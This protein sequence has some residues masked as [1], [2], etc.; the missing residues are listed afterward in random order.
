MRLLV[1]MWIWGLGKMMLMKVFVLCVRVTGTRMGGLDVIVDAGISAS[2][3]N[4]GVI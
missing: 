1:M 4:K 2:I 3:I